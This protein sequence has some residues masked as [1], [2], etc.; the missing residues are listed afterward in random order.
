MDTITEEHP[1][2]D[3]EKLGAP[4]EPGAESAAAEPR[5]RRSPLR[6]AIKTARPHEWV[7]NLL[8]FAGLLFARPVQQP[9]RHS[10]SHHRL[11]RLLRDLERRL[12]G[13]RPHDVELDRQHPKKR[14]RPI[15]AGELTAAQRGDRRRRAGR[16]RAGARLRDGQLEGRADGLRLRRRAARL[17]LRAEADRDHRRDDHR[18]LFILRVAAGAA[19]WTPMPRSGSSSARACSRVPRLHQA[20]PGSGLRASPGNRFAARCSSTTRCRS[21]TRWSRWSPPGP[22]SPTRSTRSTRRASAAR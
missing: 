8:V 21:S 14:L 6:A 15:A 22:C 16:R 10:R 17:Q 2:V 9:A 7:K 5:Q 1:V 13:Q 20:P 4:S 19:P 3:P 18:G 11:R 12:L